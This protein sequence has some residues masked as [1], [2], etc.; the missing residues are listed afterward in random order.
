MSM[1]VTV[2]AIAFAVAARGAGAQEI[3]RTLPSQLSAP[4]RATLERLIDSARVAGT[5]PLASGQS[6]KFHFTP[7]QDGY[8]YIIGPDDKGKL[9][10][11]LTSEPIPDTG[12]ETNEVENG[13]AFT[14]P[15]DEEDDKETK[16]HWVTLDKKQG[17]ENF[18]VI[19]SPTQ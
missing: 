7:R 16:E 9:M 13:D 12:V 14:F 19:Y 17:T 1:R 18:T 8:L 10:T 5:V 2:V 15:E 4:T 6:F 11:F 3:D